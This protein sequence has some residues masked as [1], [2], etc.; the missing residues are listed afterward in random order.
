MHVKRIDIS[1]MRDMSELKHKINS[2]M[3]SNAAFDTKKIYLNQ[4]SLFY[5]HSNIIKNLEDDDVVDDQEVNL[6]AI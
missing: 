5:D 1:L 4:L 6:T 3:D 2:V